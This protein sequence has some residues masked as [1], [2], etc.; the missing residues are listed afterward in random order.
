MLQGEG[1]EAAKMT[2]LFTREA[3]SLEAYVMSVLKTVSLK[4]ITVEGTH[5]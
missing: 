3:K 5:C 1:H 4:P 2:T